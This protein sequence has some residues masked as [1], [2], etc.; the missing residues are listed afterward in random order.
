MLSRAAPAG[1][2]DSRNS[3][4]VRET[5][6]AVNT[7]DSSPKNS[8]VANPRIGPGAELEQER[9][10]DERRDVGVENRQEHAIEPGGER[11][12]GALVGGQLLADALEDQ[13]VRVDADADRQDEAGDARQR[14]D[15]ADVAHEAEQ[16]DQVQRDGQD[17]VDAGQLVVHQHEHR[18]EPEPDQRREDAGAD[19]V[20]AERRT[21]L[22]LLEVVE[23][24]RQRAGPEH[25]RQILHFLLREAVR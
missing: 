1:F 13:D 5:N 3:N 17:R 2:R 18:D 14:H 6:T 4:N 21:D 23:R 24:R 19:R 10:R 8:V 20:R 25:E 22:A 12:P 7:F 11:L 16:N 15:R 9:R